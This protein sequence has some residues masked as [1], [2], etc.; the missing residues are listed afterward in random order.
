MGR[1]VYVFAVASIT[2]FVCAGVVVAQ[3]EQAQPDEEFV[4]DTAGLEAG[5]P[6]PGRYIIVL[7]DSVADPASV[8]D[9]LSGDLDLR[10]TS[11]YDD[12]I[13]GFAAEVPS[14][15]L[16]ELRADPRVEA[17]VQDRVIEAAGQ[18]R[19]TGIRRIDAD[20]S[21]ASAGN[22]KGA[23][24]VDVAILDSGIYKGH[25]DLNL[26]GGTNCTG[27]NKSAYSDGDGHGTH[28]AGTAAAR[29][30]DFGVVGVAPGARL[31]AVK[32]LGDGGSGTTSTLMCGIVCTGRTLAYRSSSWRMRTL[33]ERKPLPTGVVQGPLRATR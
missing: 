25:D 29:D 6:I 20:E 12:A 28:V 11:V 31:W 30:N 32:V 13:E 17:V 33:M 14:G 2:V 23:V 22:G 1:F 16:A 24:N 10:T 21:S 27:D 18:S 3:D 8:A 19:P 4:A 15:K 5:D 26:K 9:D 7:E